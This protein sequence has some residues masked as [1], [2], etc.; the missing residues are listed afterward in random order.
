MLTSMWDF[1]YEIEFL[2][3]NLVNLVH[4]VYATRVNTIPYMVLTV[5]HWR[6]T[7]E[8]IDQ[9]VYL[10]YVR[11]YGYWIYRSIASKC[12][13][14]AVDAVLAQDGL[15]FFCCKMC[16]WYGIRHVD[17]ALIFLLERYVWG[18]FVEPDSEALQFGL[19]YSFMSERLVD[20]QD[21]EY[22]IA[23]SSNCNYLTTSTLIMSLL[24]K[25]KRTF[26]SL[27]P[28]MIPGRSRI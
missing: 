6:Q 8:N 1:V 12:D 21:N 15:D 7:L 25:L 17:S 11:L 18:F 20:V 26:P 5:E 19:Y 2:D 16:Q 22:E 10:L 28:S 24:P 9:V 27:A 3:G 13:I 23:S 4:H 14:C